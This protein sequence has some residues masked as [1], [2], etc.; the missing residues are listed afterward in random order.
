MYTS[1]ILSFKIA[2]TFAAFRHF[3]S[4]PK[5][6]SNDFVIY[7]S[8]FLFHQSIMYAHELMCLKL[9][10]ILNEWFCFMQPECVAQLDITRPPHQRKLLCEAW[11]IF[12]QWTQGV[13]PVN[14][15]CVTAI[16]WNWLFFQPWLIH[17]EMLMISCFFTSIE[18]D[19]DN[20]WTLGAPP[21]ILPPS[22]KALL[23]LMEY[24]R[25]AAKIS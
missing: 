25:R 6:C 5:I 7:E 13:K 4:V 9:P 19:W 17:K 12:L 21:L 10:R 11:M 23:L 14:L 2:Q 24:G 16:I 20:L 22:L 3:Y 18:L 1:F 15:T 8:C